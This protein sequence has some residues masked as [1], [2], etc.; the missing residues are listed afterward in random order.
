MRRRRIVHLRR[1]RPG[2]V[3]R[4]ARRSAHGLRDG[5]AEQFRHHRGHSLPRLPHLHARNWDHPQV[6]TI[7]GVDDTIADGPISYTIITQPATSADARFA[8]FNP[9]DVQVLNYDNDFAQLAAI[10]P[11]G[12]LIYDSTI[13]GVIGTPGH[14][15]SYSLLLDPG[16]TFTVLVEPSGGLR[17]TIKVLA[18]NGTLLGSATAPAAGA[19]ALLQ[20]VQVPGQIADNGSGPKTYTVTVG[21]ANGTTGNYR[22][23]VVLNAALESESLGGT[24]DDTLATAQDING[25][26][27]LFQSAGNSG[28]QPA[29][30][31]VL[32]EVSASDPVDTYKVT[33]SAGQTTTVA[34]T[35]LNGGNAQ[36]ALLDTAGNTLASALPT[37]PT[38]SRSSSTITSSTR[39]GRTICR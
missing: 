39:P 31:A 11:P 15:E 1:G 25:S 28:Q 36:V 26:W 4:C 8:G 37:W 19:D 22:L 6:A 2:H 38:T 9:D 13:E 23:K 24:S 32:G 14:T 12:S 30:A 27:V 5:R 16:Q 17:A 20:T 7:T 29:R 3:Q 33:L 34:L 10:Q 18:P 21:G 35:V